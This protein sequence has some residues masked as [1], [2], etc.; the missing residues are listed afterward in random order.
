MRRRIYVT[1]VDGI[2]AAAAI[3]FGTIFMMTGTVILFRFLCILVNVS[4]D[5]TDIIIMKIN[6]E[7]NRIKYEM[8]YDEHK[9]GIGVYDKSKNNL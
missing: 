5:I 4:G 6:K 8:I 1:L 2:I 9:G 7:L 3:F